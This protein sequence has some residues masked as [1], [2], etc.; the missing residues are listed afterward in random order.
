MCSTFI[1]GY[2]RGRTEC[3]KPIAAHTSVM[4]TSSNE[5]S[6]RVSSNAKI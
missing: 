2:R 5:L 3:M 1:E 4:Q 6:T